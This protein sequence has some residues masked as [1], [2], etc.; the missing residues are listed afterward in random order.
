MAMTKSKELEVKLMLRASYVDSKNRPTS[1][2]VEI[3][4]L[5]T[6]GQVKRFASRKVG[7][8]RILAAAAKNEEVAR[9][10][11]KLAAI[12][13]EAPV[14]VSM[15]EVFEDDRSKPLPTT[16]EVLEEVA[17]R[18]AEDLGTKTVPGTPLVTINGRTVRPENVAKVKKGIA[19]WGALGEK[20]GEKDR[21]RGVNQAINLNY[22]LKAKV[23]PL[24]K[25]TDREWLVTAARKGLTV[26]QVMEKFNLKREQAIYKLRD[27][28]Y[29]GGHGLVTRGGKVYVIEP[30][31]K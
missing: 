15:R 2:L 16:A 9:K 7:A 31:V 20:P 19:L 5:I 29:V 3:Y 23:V 4:N 11:D 18:E 28:H 26:E 17:Q 27:L 22:P 30:E 21:L 14:K 12:N 25:G 24:R 8:K 1:E 13:V 10:L 6:G